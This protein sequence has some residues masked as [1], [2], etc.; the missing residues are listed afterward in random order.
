MHNKK[1]S[2]TTVMIFFYTIVQKCMDVD[3]RSRYQSVYKFCSITK[4]YA[5]ILKLRIAMGTCCISNIKSS[6]S[7]RLSVWYFMP[8]HKKCNRFT[9][10]GIYFAAMPREKQKV[11]YVFQNFYSAAFSSK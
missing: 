10:A 11:S 5:F 8:Q 7:L 9:F 3:V 2:Y 6:V 4:L 1:L